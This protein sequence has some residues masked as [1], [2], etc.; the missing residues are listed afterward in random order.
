MKLK[1]PD[2]YQITIGRRNSLI[3]L[4]WVPVTPRFMSR[5]VEIKT[6]RFSNFDLSFRISIGMTK[7][8]EGAQLYRLCI[9]RND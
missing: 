5:F 7:L 8:S 2:Q 6:N 9:S 3:I 4:G 1:L